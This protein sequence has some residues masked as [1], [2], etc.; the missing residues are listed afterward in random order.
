MVDGRL[1]R[2]EDDVVPAIFTT[3]TFESAQ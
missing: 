2:D 3:P 1:R